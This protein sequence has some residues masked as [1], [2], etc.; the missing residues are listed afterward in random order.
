MWRFTAV[1]NCMLSSLRRLVLLCAHRCVLIC[2]CMCMQNV[3]PQCPQAISRYQGSAEASSVVGAHD[4]H[5]F[6]KEV[7]KRIGK[8]GRSGSGWGRQRE[9]P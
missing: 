2:C 4:A 3:M 8:A 5:F 1:R 6:K 9:S 7:L